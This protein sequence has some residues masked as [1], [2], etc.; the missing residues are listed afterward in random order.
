MAKRG[1][2]DGYKTYDTSQGY[3]SPYQWRAAFRE[4]MGIDEARN[5]M[6]DDSPHGV[7]GVALSATWA[8]IK[9][10]YRKLARTYHPDV[11]KGADAEERMKKINAAY[12]VLEDKFGK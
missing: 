10:A 6:G 11:Y 5:V 3:G 12:V 4:R 2:M 8:E 9:S 1:F 7:L